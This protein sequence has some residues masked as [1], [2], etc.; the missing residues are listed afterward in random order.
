MEKSLILRNRH[1]QVQIRLPGSEPA[2]ERFDSAAVVEQV[3]LRGRHSFCQPEQKLADRVTCWGFGL[4]AEFDLNHL[5]EEAAKGQLFPKPGVGLLTQIEDGKPYDMWSHYA[6]QRFRKTWQ[7]GT[8]W[9]TFLEEPD[10]CLGIALRIRR[11]L[12]LVENQIFLTT[13]IENVGERR[14]CFSEY[15]HNFVAIDDI[16]IAEG[17]CLTIPFDGTLDRLPRSFHRLPDYEPIQEASVQV[18]GQAARWIQPM[19][20]RAYHKTTPADQILPADV[21]QWTLSHAASP[22]SITETM[23]FKPSKLVLWG[24]EHCVCPEVYHAIDVSP[25]QTDTYKRVWRF[26][27]NQTKGD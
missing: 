7:H 25:G 3:I 13:T 11:E 21:Y 26:D 14:V 4:N 18:E 15:Q 5:G 23:D 27:D 24:I 9:I 19:D 2:S 6:I 20:Q 16:P 10:P 17:Y 22:A 12:R 8:D 1:L